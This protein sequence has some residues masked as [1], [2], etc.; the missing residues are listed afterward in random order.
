MKDPVAPEGNCS[1][2]FGEGMV[3]GIKFSVMQNVNKNNVF[4]QLKKLLRREMSLFL[5]TA[6]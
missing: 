2:S 1:F 3:I 5:L 6:A 4:K